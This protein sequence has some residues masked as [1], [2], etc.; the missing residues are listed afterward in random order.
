M[1]PAADG[2]DAFGRNLWALQRAGYEHHKAKPLVVRPVTGFS[3][4]VDLELVGETRGRRKLNCEAR[5]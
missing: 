4:S 1:V 2:R 3:A 5:P